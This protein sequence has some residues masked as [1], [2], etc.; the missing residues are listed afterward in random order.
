MTLETK[1]AFARRLGVNKSTITRAAQAGRLVLEGGKV[2]VERSLAQW[3]ATAGAVRPD[4]VAHWAVQRGA[5]LPA[6]QPGA[7]NA[8]TPD[9]ASLPGIVALGLPLQQ[10]TAPGASTAITDAGEELS[11]TH[12][13]AL[14]LQYEN[15]SIKLDIA[16]RRHQ[17]Y[18]LPAV[19]RESRAL[20]ATLRASVE[21]LI[22][23][24][25]PRLAAARDPAARL[26]L[27]QAECASVQAAMRKEFVRALRR[28][29]EQEVPA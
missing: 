18:A 6:P 15:A 29:R 22:D 12:Y 26:G 25:A 17:R 11:R 23:Q 24:T 14:T 4:M 20:G 10:L 21:R 8:L 9:L 3:H 2:N 16:L 7:E 1:A 28:L 27:L 5:Q 19:R 13:K